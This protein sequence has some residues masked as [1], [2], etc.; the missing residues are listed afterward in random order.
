MFPRSP[1]VKSMNSRPFPGHVR[2][3]SVYSSGDVICP[4]TY[5]I[6][7]PHD[8]DD[9]RNVLVRRLGHM[10]L[11]EDPFVYGLILRELMGRPTDAA[12][13]PVAAVPT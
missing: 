4:Y 13:G 6:L 8:G 7:T 5:S 9:V 11:V 10:D 1:L 12:S 2:L 3:V